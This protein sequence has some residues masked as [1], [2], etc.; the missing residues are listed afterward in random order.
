MYFK[1]EPAYIHCVPTIP[2]NVQ[3]QKG[4]SLLNELKNKL[5]WLAVGPVV[6]DGVGSECLRVSRQGERW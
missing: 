2:K 5:T 1:L 3:L 4:S 6:H